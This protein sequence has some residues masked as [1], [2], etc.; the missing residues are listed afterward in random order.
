MTH[1]DLIGAAIGCGA[2][3]DGCKDGPRALL[4]AGALARLHTPYAHAALVHDIE[5][6]TSAGH[7]RS[8]R[9]ASPAQAHP[10]IA[11]FAARSKRRSR[12][13]SMKSDNAL[14]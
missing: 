13:S 5:L 10:L 6:A 7:S 2:Q 9:L 12:S 11:R 1:I 4:Q 3:D 8:A 14:Q